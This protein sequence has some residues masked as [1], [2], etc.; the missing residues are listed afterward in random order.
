MDLAQYYLHILTVM[1]LNLDCLTAT[2][3]VLTILELT[4]QEMLEWGVKEVLQPV[5][6]I[7]IL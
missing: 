6:M 1:E 5:S 3:I 2:H 7:I 4:M